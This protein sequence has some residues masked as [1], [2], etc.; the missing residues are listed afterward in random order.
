MFQIEENVSLAQFTTFGVGGKARYFCEP[1]NKEGVKYA[2]TFAKEKQIPV[3]VLGAGSNLLVSDDGYEGLVVRQA[4]TGISVLEKSDAAISVYVGAGEAWDRFV[5]W[6][7]EHNCAG[8]E[9][10]SG[11][12]GTVGGFIFENAGAY[13]QNCN[14]HIVSIDAFDGKEGVW[15]TFS[16]DESDF[17]YHMSFF[18][19]NTGRYFIAGARFD[20]P[21]SETVC[22]RCM[23]KDNKFDFSKLFPET[24]SMPS[25][26]QMR[27]AILR[28]RGDKGM[29][30]MD[31]FESFKSVGSFF[32]LPPVSR[33]KFLEIEQIANTI[34]KKKA[35]ELS[36]WYWEHNDGT[37]KIAPAFLLEFTEFVKG[38]RCGNVG[39]SPKHSL[40]VV[41]YGGTAREIKS[42]AENMQKK[43][44]ELFGVRLVPEVTYIGFPA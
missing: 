36:P 16:K 38:Y 35:L 26:T 24:E 42:L 15:R 2:Y 8:I 7:V 3:F 22:T 32:G 17:S 25:L 44:F 27:N 18:K 5:L 20:F 39:I 21:R 41:N 33:E 11:I 30:I 43:V 6:V 13:R 40:A 28:V 37:V 23:Y 10:L 29:L 4:L 14:D 31:G 34:N 12:P 19:K 1:K 9:C